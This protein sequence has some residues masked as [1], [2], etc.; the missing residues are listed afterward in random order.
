MQGCNW[1]L[2]ANVFNKKKSFA[3]FFMKN[4]FMFMQPSTN[5]LIPIYKTMC[6]DA[7]SS[8]LRIQIQ[9]LARKPSEYF[10]T[11]NNQFTEY[12]LPR[13][14]K[15]CDS[16]TE[17][18]HSHMIHTETKEI[19]PYSYYN[20]NKKLMF[21]SEYLTRHA[22]KDSYGCTLLSDIHAYS[23]SYVG[24]LFNSILLKSKQNSLNEKEMRSLVLLFNRIEFLSGQLRNTPYQEPVERHLKIW[25]RLFKTVEKEWQN[26]KEKKAAPYE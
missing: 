1:C 11:K 7:C 15:T 9:K 24:T 25:T 18:I 2:D 14:V 19:F 12:D 4:Y 6:V 8:A 17:F 5:E 26:K 21:F 3:Q 22:P 10:H 20:K 13:A 23:L 16:I